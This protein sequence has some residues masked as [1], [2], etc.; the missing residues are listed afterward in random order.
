MSRKSHLSQLLNNIE[1][2]KYKNYKLL[3]EKK[4]LQTKIFFEVQGNESRSF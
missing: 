2:V 4:T 3:E 1:D